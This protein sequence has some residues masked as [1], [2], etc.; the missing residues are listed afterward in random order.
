MTGGTF[1]LASCMIC[2]VFHATSLTFALITQTVNSWGDQGFT[3]YSIMFFYGFV[4]LYVLISAAHRHRQSLIRQIQLSIDNQALITELESA[5]S[6]AES[7]SRAKSSF[8]ATMS[9]EI[10]TPL[11]GLMGML[12]ILRDDL[13]D[14]S[15]A[16]SLETMDRSANILLKLLNDTLDYSKIEV[17]KLELEEVNFNWVELIKE[18]SGLMRS[19]AIAKGLAFETEITGTEVKML[20]GDSNRLNQIIGNLLSNAIKFTE[21]GRVTLRVS[22]SMSNS[23][24]QYQL[25]IE[26]QDTGVG[27]KNDALDRIFDRFS[28][29]D[30]STTRKFG[31]T[32]LGLAI[33]RKLANL[34]G[35]DISCSSTYGKGSTF[36]LSPIFSIC[37]DQNLLIIH[38]IKRFSAIFSQWFMRGL[39]SWSMMIKLAEKS[40]LG[41]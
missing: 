7:E 1:T 8:L 14:A 34:M 21:N 31:G 30:S 24:G 17:G 10:R 6:K 32:G 18:I 23:S 33:S 16:E 37:E 11:N 4:L 15:H 3:L 19:S 25:K 40:L 22:G 9:H 39:L 26:V 5:K 41:C 13:K 20:R 35:S 12:Q 28:Q 38:P 2:V 27:I 36:V 29:A